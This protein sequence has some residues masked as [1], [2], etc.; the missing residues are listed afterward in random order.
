MLEESEKNIGVKCLTY[1]SNYEMG[2]WN[3]IDTYV[4][5]WWKSSHLM[6]ILEGVAW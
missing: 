1:T 5:E 3:L 4:Q 6:V 2:A